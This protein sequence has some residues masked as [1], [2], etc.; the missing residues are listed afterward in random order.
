MPNTRFYQRVRDQLG[1][2][3]NWNDSDD[4]CVMFKGAYTDDFYR[5]IRD[6]L[7]LEVAGWSGDAESAVRAQSLWR[8]VERREQLSRNHDAT[9]LPTLQSP[10]HVFVPLGALSLEA[11]D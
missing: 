6:A 9:E 3:R 8:E 7:H 1:A 4:L 10:G 5:V 2:K 11:T